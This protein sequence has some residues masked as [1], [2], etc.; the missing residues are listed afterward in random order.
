M[1]AGGPGLGGP[2][3]SRGR[4]IMMAAHWHS[5]AVRLEPPPESLIQLA[6]HSDS[7]RASDGG[8]WLRRPGRRVTVAAR[9]GPGGAA[10]GG[11]P[12]RRL[13]L[14]LPGGVTVLVTPTPSPA[15]S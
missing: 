10:T 13:A 2:G 7:S 14:N 5:V 3:D 11:T 4:R 6:S 12:R 1:P 15:G 8:H 9:P